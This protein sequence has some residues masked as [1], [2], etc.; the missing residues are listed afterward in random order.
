MGCEVVN[1]A[2]EVRERRPSLFY[3]PEVGPR[4]MRLKKKRA[5]A[6]AGWPN[7]RYEDNIIYIPEAHR[8][9]GPPPLAQCRRKNV[10]VVET[11]NN[12]FMCSKPLLL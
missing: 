9:P 12:V 8:W 3:D 4:V 2:P 11:L 1:D 7:R 10:L 6:V 5:G